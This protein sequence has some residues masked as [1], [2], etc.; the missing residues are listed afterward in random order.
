MLT[1]IALAANAHGAPMSVAD[2]LGN[3]VEVRV[4]CTLKDEAAPHQRPVR[5]AVEATQ[6]LT[7]ISPQTY[8]LQPRSTS[9]IAKVQW[10]LATMSVGGPITP[11]TVKVTDDQSP[12]E[13]CV[14]EQISLRPLASS[15]EIQVGDREG[16]LDPSQPLFNN[17]VVSDE[18]GRISKGVITVSLVN[19]NGGAA[20]SIVG[21]AFSLP[22]A[23]SAVRTQVRYTS[24]AGAQSVELTLKADESVGVEKFSE[25]VREIRMNPAL[26]IP[27]DQMVQVAIVLT[28]VDGVLTEA[29]AQV[30]P[31]SAIVSPGAGGA[32]ALLKDITL[33]ERGDSGQ[34]MIRC[35]V[36]SGMIRSTKDLRIKLSADAP[37]VLDATELVEAKVAERDTVMFNVGA[38]WRD[39]APATNSRAE[40]HVQVIDREYAGT[41]CE[42]AQVTLNPEAPTLSVSAGDNA[43]RSFRPGGP[44]FGQVVLADE[45]ASI[46][47]A[48]ITLRFTPNRGV[49]L[50]QVHQT[51]V[52]NPILNLPSGESGIVNSSVV[53]VDEAARPTL[54]LSFTGRASV[55]SY[56][57]VLGSIRVQEG[58]L[59][60]TFAAVDVRLEV[61]DA[62]G[63]RVQTAVTMPMESVYVE[64]HDQAWVRLRLIE[65][66]RDGQYDPGCLAKYQNETVYVRSR[67]DLTRV[68]VQVLLD[69]KLWSEH[70]GSESKQ[71]TH[72]DLSIVSPGDQPDWDQ[73]SRSVADCGTGGCAKDLIAG[74]SRSLV[75]STEVV[76]IAANVTLEREVYVR[77]HLADGTFQVI[78]P[79]AVRATWWDGAPF[80]EISIASRPASYGVT[81]V[82]CQ[83]LFDSDSSQVSTICE[84]TPF[85]DY[86]TSGLSAAPVSLHARFV[87]FAKYPMLGV[88]AD[89]ALSILGTDPQVLGAGA[90]PTTVSGSEASAT[91][92]L[93]LDGQFQASLGLDVRLPINDRPI[94]VMYYVGTYQR[95]VGGASR[96]RMTTGVTLIAPILIADQNDVERARYK[97]IRPSDEPSADSADVE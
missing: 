22:A 88:S 16:I 77:L 34:L 91:N 51:L 2:E 75:D 59:L 15:L 92:G 31:I 61:V 27:P 43:S 87:P 60:S 79:R 67:E 53:S 36:P 80:Y 56:N 69:P 49:T 62:D 70:R 1:L 58:L 48:Q 29:T 96:L 68:Q 10:S 30:L 3:V 97:L 57:R 5:L 12:I 6:P 38:R 24:V 95:D 7:L 65:Y 90:S 47:A 71:V 20:A 28:D 13:A 64:V 93:A 41:S 63:E 45:D 85:D 18:D 55:E 40:V 52:Q 86:W 89:M 74:A 25:Y 78:G 42:V 73:S 23:G 21:P 17:F 26:S 14:A 32:G 84:Q 72:V 54:V 94:D 44:L 50:D 33:S 46:D 83:D 76:D 66:S 8:D 11:L 19:P 35:T 81:H 82:Y 9:F 39:P 4:D 37:I